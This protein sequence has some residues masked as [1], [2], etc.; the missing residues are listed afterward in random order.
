MFVRHKPPRRNFSL[1]DNDNLLHGPL[2]LLIKRRALI[3]HDNLVEAG[4]STTN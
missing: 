4:Y 3:L 1:I 2:A